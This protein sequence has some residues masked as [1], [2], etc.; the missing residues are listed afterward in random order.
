[1][2]YLLC[3]TASFTLKLFQM[4]LGW[5]FIAPFVQADGNLPPLLRTWF[6]PIDSPAIGDT[7]YANKEALF[8]TN[9]PRWLSYYIRAVMW[10]A[11]N[12]A[13]GWDNVC[14]FTIQDSNVHSISGNPMVD[15]GTQAT[16]GLV[17][18]SLTQNN[19]TYFDWK[20]AGAWTTNYGY[21]LRFGWVMNSFAIG[22][23]AQLTIDVRPLIKL[24]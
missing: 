6:Q 10:G 3:A 13:Y 21:M 17:T 24:P 22:Y 12:P 11:R 18:R 5:L 8:T 2:I 20:Y 4:S 9:Y 14:G 19:I 1:M 23:R 16:F 7:A 15:I